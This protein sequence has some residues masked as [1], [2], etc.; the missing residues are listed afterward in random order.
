M[1]KSYAIVGAVADWAE[2]IPGDRPKTKKK[3]VGGLFGSA[4]IVK[5]FKE[6]NTDL[7]EVE[8]DYSSGS[9]TPASYEGVSGGPLWEL[10]TELDGNRVIKV[11]K[12]LHGI[13]FRQSD[14]HR[15]ITCNG[16]SSIDNLVSAIKAKWPESRQ[17]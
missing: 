4:K 7:V 12:R 16:G 15:L 6:N 13:A 17:G 2:D 3:I 1:S 14:D 9:K 10:Y 5:E 11:N 8:I